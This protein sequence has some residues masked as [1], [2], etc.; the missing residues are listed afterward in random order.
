MDVTSWRIT[1]VSKDIEP[2]TG[3]EVIKYRLETMVQETGQ[4]FVLMET[5]DLIHIMLTINN[6][7]LQPVKPSHFK[8]ITIN[9]DE[10]KPTGVDKN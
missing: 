4:W 1:K 2:F 9:H 7:V 3:G 6:T 5:Y 10:E 8:L